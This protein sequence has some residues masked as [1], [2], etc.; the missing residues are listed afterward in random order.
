M[1]DLRDVEWAKGVLGWWRDHATSALTRTYRTASDRHEQESYASLGPKVDALRER[2][3]QTRVVLSRVLGLEKLPVIIELGVVPPGA[4]V[5]RRLYRTPPD[6]ESPAPL[7]VRFRDNAGQWWA[8]NEHGVLLRLKRRLPYPP[9]RV[10]G[11]SL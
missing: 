9:L 3:H 10:G 1:A 6:A 7:A 4:S 11:T 2:E 5:D 8:R